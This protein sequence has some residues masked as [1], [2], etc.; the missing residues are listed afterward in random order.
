MQIVRE[1]EMTI[2]LGKYKASCA[3]KDEIIERLKI[4]PMSYSQIWAF[5]KVSKTQMSSYIISLKNFGL[6]ESRGNSPRDPNL[7]YHYIGKTNFT[8]ALIARLEENSKFR[9]GNKKFGA[10]DVRFDPRAS[11]KVTTNTHHTHGNK[12]KVSAWQGYT[13]FGGM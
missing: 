8:D 10:D 12:S 2:H 11:M 7:V 1:K 3:I 9:K 6:I 13:S 4:K 5:Y